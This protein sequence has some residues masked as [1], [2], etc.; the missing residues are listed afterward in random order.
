MQRTIFTSLQTLL[1]APCD[2]SWWPLIGSPNIH[3]QKHVTKTDG[4]AGVVGG[5][6]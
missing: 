6:S 1:E 4:G 2:E 3:K 5:I